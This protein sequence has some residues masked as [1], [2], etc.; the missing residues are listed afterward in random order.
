M[1]EENAVSVSESKGLSDN[2]RRKRELSFV[3][4]KSIS[5]FHQNIDL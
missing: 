3:W 5:R 1:K 4:R 2:E